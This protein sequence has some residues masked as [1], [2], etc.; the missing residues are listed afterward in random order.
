MF[1][2][3][4]FIFRRHRSFALSTSTIY[5]GL[6][7]LL[8]LE[9]NIIFFH[10][11]AGCLCYNKE[12]NGGIN[13]GACEVDPGTSHLTMIMLRTSVSRLQLS[14]STDFLYV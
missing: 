10:F 4:L 11:G 3:A 8:T 1:V 9:Q 12:A 14:L 7:E 5:N 2:L 13:G 6:Q